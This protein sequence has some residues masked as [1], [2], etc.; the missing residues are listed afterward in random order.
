MFTGSQYLDYLVRLSLLLVLTSVLKYGYKDILQ[1][2]IA[3][4]P[5]FKLAS[6]Q[7]SNSVSWGIDDPVMELIYLLKFSGYLQYIFK[8]LDIFQLLCHNKI[9][10]TFRLHF[11]E[12]C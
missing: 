3:F 11:G 1:N 8:C 4:Q 6:P 7:I 10:V 12:D 5:F 9:Y 2:M